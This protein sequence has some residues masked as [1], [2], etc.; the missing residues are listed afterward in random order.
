MMIEISRRRDD[1][2]AEQ[3]MRSGAKRRRVVLQLVCVSEN[4]A[5]SLAP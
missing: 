1:E 2:V 5:I 4:M 3:I